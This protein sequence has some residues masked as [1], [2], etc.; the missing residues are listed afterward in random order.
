[1]EKSLLLITALVAMSIQCWAV[2]V[3]LSEPA[4]GSVITASVESIDVGD[5]TIGYSTSKS[6]K[7]YGQSLEGDVSIAVTGRQAS[8]IEV[9]PAVI[10]PE[11]AAAGATVR[12]KFSPMLVGPTT[13]VLTLSSPGAASVV[14]PVVGQAQ[15]I[16]TTI[17]G[18][19]ASRT[20]QATVGA[21]KLTSCTE[22]IRW[23]DA[24]IPEPPV[25]DEVMGTGGG[26]VQ[27]MA[28]PGGGS[29]FTDYQVTVEGSSCISATI[30]KGSPTIKTCQLRISYCPN[31]IGQH[32]ATV[33][34]KCSRAWYDVVI[35]VDG[36]ATLG[37]SDPVATAPAARETTATSFVARWTQSCPAVGVESFVLQCAPQGVEFDTGEG[38]CRTYTDLDPS[39]CNRGDGLILMMGHYR[40][41][42]EDLTEDSTYCYRVK[43]RYIDGT[44]SA[45]SNIMTV[46]LADNADAGSP[47]DANGD[48]QLNITDVS[49]LI[50]RLL[51]GNSDEV[52]ERH[53]DLSVDVNDDGQFSISDITLL[54]GSLM[55]GD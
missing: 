19:T 42:I 52:E 36:I 49:M 55:S 43:A 40:L 21:L 27:L 35:T 29:S 7:V 14:I 30:V 46:A 26:D 12:V 50:N 18:R 39:E 24:G 10:T 48:G 6:F 54:I 23:A 37:K 11:A 3:D 22:V 16:E 47:G 51:V 31:N 41:P 9:T 32:H 17:G 15:N 28:L 25:Q 53:S 33:T 2:P 34:V 4:D 13:E 8:A 20:L 1:M 44:E 38:R 5:V 45:W